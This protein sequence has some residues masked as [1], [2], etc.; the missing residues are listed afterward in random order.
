MSAGKT[1]FCRQYYY[2]IENFRE[3]VEKNLENKKAPLYLQRC[4]FIPRSVKK[5]P[6]IHSLNL[7]FRTVLLLEFGIILD[8]RIVLANI[9]FAVL[10]EC[11]FVVFS[12]A[13]V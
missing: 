5:D 9:G 8:F 6:G 7:L 12:D 11:N 1:K 2:S 13:L 4:F 3:Y 10:F